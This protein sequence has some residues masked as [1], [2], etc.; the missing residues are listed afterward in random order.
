MIIVL[1]LMGALA[2]AAIVATIVETARDG[3]RRL[4]TRS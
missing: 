1:A 2:A 4:P 3:Y